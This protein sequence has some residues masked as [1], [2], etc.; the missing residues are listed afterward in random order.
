[1]YLVSWYVVHLHGT[2][3]SGVHGPSS[4]CSLCHFTNLFKP[5]IYYFFFSGGISIYYLQQ[6][7]RYDTG[8]WRNKWHLSQLYLL[9]FSLLDYKLHVYLVLFLAPQF[10][11]QCLTLCGSVHF[12]KWVNIPHTTITSQSFHAHTHIVSGILSICQKSRIYSY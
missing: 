3:I 6:G 2:P 8:F 7:R 11:T 12:V 4:L 1:M 9:V 5:S 10:P